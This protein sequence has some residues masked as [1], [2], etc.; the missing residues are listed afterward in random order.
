MVNKM[1]KLS[2]IHTGIRITTKS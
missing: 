1:K 2:G